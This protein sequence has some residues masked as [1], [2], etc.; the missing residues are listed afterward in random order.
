MLWV[1]GY[2]FS[3]LLQPSDGL[4]YGLQWDNETGRERC[5]PCAAGAFSQWDETYHNRTCRSCPAG[6]RMHRGLCTPCEAGTFNGY[7]GGTACMPCLAGEYQ[8]LPGQTAC[9][10]C[11]AGKFSAQSASVAC[12]ACTD[13]FDASNPNEQRRFAPEGSASCIACPVGGICMPDSDGLYTNYSNSD[14]YYFFKDQVTT[15]FGSSDMGLFRCSHGAGAACKADGGCYR[16]ESGRV[17]MTGPMCGTCVEGFAKPV[18]QD[19][20]LCVECSSLAWNLFGVAMQL[21]TIMAMLAFLMA[22]N[23]ISDFSKPKTMFSIVLKQIFNYM[24][25]AAACFGTFGN[26][27]LYG[28]SGVVDTLQSV[29]DY[30][31]LTSSAWVPLSGPCLIQYFLPTWHVHQILCLVGMFWF[32][33]TV[34][35][36]I[37][38]FYIIRLVRM[39]MGLKGP[40]IHRLKTWLVI[41]VF[42]CVT[43]VNQLLMVTFGCQTYDT[44]RL[45]LNTQI[46]CWSDEH[47]LWQ[48]LSWSGILIFSIG[49]PFFLYRLLRNYEKQDLLLNGRVSKTYGFLYAGFDNKCYYFECLYMF[50]KLCFELM[51]RIPGM[52]SDD[53][54]ILGRIQNS[55]LAFVASIFFAVHMYFQ[56]YDNRGYFIL[57]RIETASLR[58]ILVTAFLQLWC[59]IT[60]DADV[61]VG[62]PTF[63]LVRN[64][65]CT[66]IIVYMHLRFFW[67]VTWGLGRRRITY[68][69]ETL[70]D[71]VRVYQGKSGHGTSKNA[72]GTVTFAPDGLHLRNLNYLEEAL[73]ESMFADMLR[74][75]HHMKRKLSFDHWSG[76]L[77][78]MC[79]EAQRS[80]K[81][82]AVQSL[83]AVGNTLRQ[84]RNMSKKLFK[85][86]RVG[87]LVEKFLDRCEE[88]YGVMS[89]TGSHAQFI[90]QKMKEVEE[91]RHFSPDSLNLILNR[92]FSVEELQDAMLNLRKGLCEEKRIAGLGTGKE[93]AE[94]DV[95][96]TNDVAFYVGKLDMDDDNADKLR[97]RTGLAELDSLKE[98]LRERIHEC[99]LL[100]RQLNTLQQA[101]V[102]SP[103]G[104]PRRLSLSNKLSL[105]FGASEHDSPTEEVPKADSKQLL[106]HHEH[107]HGSNP[108]DENYEAECQVLLKELEAKNEEIKRHE[109]VFREQQSRIASL[110]AQLAKPFDEGDVG[111]QR[112]SYGTL[113]S[114]SPGS[115]QSSAAAARPVASGEE[116]TEAPEPSEGR[117]AS[118]VATTTV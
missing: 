89:T 88:F 24:Q 49:G 108:L 7:F 60:N 64:W 81:E 11:P 55:S 13:T 10:K 107:R 85:D 105:S 4:S 35:L 51:T 84:Y 110:E 42:L 36:S 62:N 71:A 18:G 29:Q 6:S 54:A 80:A 38:G 48:L 69:Y 103:R 68:W 33:A 47:V 58:A 41:N 46:D 1:D 19:L 76:G 98:E 77:Q 79:L 27:G 93:V 70:R 74:L 31:G 113:E 37:L 59:I 12:T 5:L 9:E 15:V 53:E 99:H 75:H 91:L 52:T 96:P 109:E 73:L 23:A 26:H 116:E 101:E 67:I 100:R 112:T 83:D 40:S 50:R 39:A 90:R 114:N 22:V 2:C 32:P 78:L 87:Q 63:V 72:H 45:N 115:R 92:E 14:S 43:R 95:P 25:M 3:K 30:L 97:E 65:A 66:A 102:T 82:A 117:R 21:S 28:G 86:G 118:G 44:S 61:A 17:T 57:D 56:P 34:V 104:G 106:L 20:G 111:L 8:P 94:E 16:D